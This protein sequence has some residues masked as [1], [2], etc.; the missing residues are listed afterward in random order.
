M[1]PTVHLGLA[2]TLHFHATGAVTYLAGGLAAL[3][4]IIVMDTRGIVREFNPA[5]EAATSPGLGKGSV[6]TL[7]LPVA[8]RAS[9]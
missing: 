7:R 8:S 6:L 3:D 1:D 2:P 5:A 4:C 9:A